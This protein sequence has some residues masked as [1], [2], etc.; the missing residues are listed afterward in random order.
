MDGRMLRPQIGARLALHRPETDTARRK[1]VVDSCSSSGTFW[2][3]RPC[4]V[5]LAQPS[6]SLVGEWLVVIVT[7][8]LHSTLANHKAVQK[9]SRG[10]L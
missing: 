9:V 8:C 3:V 1:G 2:S 6:W 4:R 7:T 5:F 10:R